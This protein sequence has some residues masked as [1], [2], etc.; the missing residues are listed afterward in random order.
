MSLTNDETILPNAAPMIIPIAMSSTLPRIM[1]FLNSSIMI[2]T[3][4][5][6]LAITIAIMSYHNGCVKT[7]KAL[8]IPNKCPEFVFYIVCIPY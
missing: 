5:Y 4:L 1:N 7:K 3:L 6:L 8:A 2:A